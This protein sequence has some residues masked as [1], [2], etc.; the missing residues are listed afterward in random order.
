MTCFLNV[1]AMHMSLYTTH[2]IITHHL[3]LLVQRMRYQGLISHFE[4]ESQFALGVR[5]SRIAT[6]AMSPSEPTSSTKLGGDTIGSSSSITLH[7]LSFIMWLVLCGQL[8][9]VAVFGAEL[10]V[11]RMLAVSERT[12]AKLAEARFWFIN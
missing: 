12:R 2:D 8:I 11:A 5:G 6:S 4:K 7:E 3:N 1:V 9:S 10:L